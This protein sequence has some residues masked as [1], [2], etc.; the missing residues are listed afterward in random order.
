MVSAI[1]SLTRVSIIL[2]ALVP[3]TSPGLVLSEFSIKNFFH[4][5]RMR[6]SWSASGCFT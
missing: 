1:F 3:M 4:N 5:N 2:P 6:D